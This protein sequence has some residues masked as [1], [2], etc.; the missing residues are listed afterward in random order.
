M[1]LSKRT[2]SLP[3][4]TLESFEQVVPAGERSALVAALLKEWLERRRRDQLRRRIAEGCKDMAEV[5]LDIERA[6][7]PLEEE[8]HRALEGSTASRRRGASASRS[9]RRIRTGR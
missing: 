1:H 4:P 6:F 3:G 8:V 7:H 9:R 2:Y 5:Y